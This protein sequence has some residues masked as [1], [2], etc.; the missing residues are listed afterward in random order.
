[1]K[2]LIL[3]LLFVSLAPLQCQGQSTIDIS[4][5]PKTFVGLLL[6][7]NQSWLTSSGT[8]LPYAGAQNTE[9][10]T[11]PKFGYKIGV[12]MRHEL[13][14]RLFLECSPAYVYDQTSYNRDYTNDY[15][16]SL[17]YH[18]SFSWLELP[19]AINYSFINKDKF[20]LFAGVGF[21]ARKLVESR[22]SFTTTL[23]NGFSASGTS[24]GRVNDWNFLPSVQ[25]G[26]N[27]WISDAS[28]LTVCLTYQRSTMEFYKKSTYPPAYAV[29]YE[30]PDYALN[31][32]QLAVAY[33]V[34]IRSL[35]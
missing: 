12:M 8:N 15:P 29:S 18:S 24:D 20:S 30:A 22:M 11:D 6:A 34:N 31:S 1:M 7:G 26:G 19:L 14:R 28:K 3:I 32:F 13:G 23:G 2:N 33:L 16:I 21:A 35:K 17:T 27:I 5:L 25:I 4:K 9:I 10:S